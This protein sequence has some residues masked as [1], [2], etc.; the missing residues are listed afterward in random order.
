MGGWVFEYGGG[1]VRTSI[2]TFYHMSGV[3]YLASGQSIFEG[4]E[5]G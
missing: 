5:S 1:R 4:G 3:V 2:G